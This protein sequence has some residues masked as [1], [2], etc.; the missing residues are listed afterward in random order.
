VGSRRGRHADRGAAGLFYAGGAPEALAR[1]ATGGAAGFVAR[2]T[3][4]VAVRARRWD[5]VAAHWLA[6]SAWAALATRGPLLAIAHGGDVHLLAQRRLLGPTLRALALR[7]ARV[8]CVSSAARDAVRAADPRAQPLVQP[9]GVD[10]DATAAIIAARAARPPASPITIAILARL[11]PIKG[12]DVALAALAQLPARCTLV[13]AGDGP[14][15]AALEHRAAALGVSARV[16]FVGWLDAAARDALLAAADAV[17]VPSIATPDGRS[18]G[19]PLAALEAL[20]C[21]RAGGRDRDRR[22]RRARRVWRAHRP[23]ARSA[24]ASDRHRACRDPADRAGQRA[25]VARG[26]RPARRALEASGA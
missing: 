23:P 2:L 3:A 17:C 16:R 11:V 26:G 12:L 4:A 5:A 15:R 25:R 24:G 9:M 14:A 21:W 13:V 20:A 7:G 19:T 1:G 10:D 22:P 8:A 6:P 18:E